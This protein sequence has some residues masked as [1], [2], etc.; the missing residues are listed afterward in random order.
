VWR[1]F[2]LEHVF[3]KWAPVSGERHAQTN[4]LKRLERI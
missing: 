1:S 4:E 3:L 2:D